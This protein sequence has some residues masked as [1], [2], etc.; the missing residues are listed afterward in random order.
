MKKIL[1]FAVLIAAAAA[2][3]AA[4]GKRGYINMERVFN[5]YYK[6]INENINTENQVKVFND[7]YEVL[8]DEYKNS[9]KEFQKAAADADNELLSAEARA[10]AASKA[11]AL[12]QRL[13]QKQSELAEY[14]QRVGGELQDKQQ[15]QVEVLVEDLIAQ[16]KKFADERGYTEV[17]EVSGRSMNRVPMVL[18]YPENDDITDAVIAV[19]NAGHEKEKAEASARLTELRAKMEAEMKARQSA[20]A[21]EGL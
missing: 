10:A 16:V 4:D 7:G 19:T 5:E 12:A 18:V 20:A 17:L 9:V 6:T 13:Q 14:R 2:L 1:T 11:D 21:A 8:R 3:F 15:R